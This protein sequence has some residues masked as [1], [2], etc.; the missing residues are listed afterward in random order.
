MTEPYHFRARRAGQHR[1]G[2]DP[3]SD[4]TPG[5]SQGI[6]ALYDAVI[7]EPLPADFLKLLDE[8]GKKA[9]K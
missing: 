1:P 6:R 2:H 3:H 4:D 9:A 7:Q 5:W 8:L